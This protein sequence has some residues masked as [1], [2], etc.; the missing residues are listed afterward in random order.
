MQ[1]EGAGDQDTVGRFERFEPLRERGRSVVR[2]VQGTG[3]PR[4]KTVDLCS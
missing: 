4:S 3:A 2:I 1:G